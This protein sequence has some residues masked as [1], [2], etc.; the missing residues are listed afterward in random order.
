M[1]ELTLFNY[2]QLER[3]ETRVRR[4]VLA[5]RGEIHLNKMIIIFGLEQ[6]CQS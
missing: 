6:I 2:N 1:V 3:S 5:K 4:D